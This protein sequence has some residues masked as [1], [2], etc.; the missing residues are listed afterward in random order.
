[1]FWRFMLGASLLANLVLAALWYRAST[2][3]DAPAP[4]PPALTNTAG[5]TNVRTAV[6]VRRQF[7]SW[8]ELESPDYAVY[9]GN[10]RA[11]GCPEET[12]R[13][14]LL[15]DVNQMLRAKYPPDEVAPNPRWWTN[16]RPDESAREEPGRALNFIKERND[17]MTQLFGPNWTPGP[18]LNSRMSTAPTNQIRATLEADDH[19]RNLTPGQKQ[20]VIEVLGAAQLETSGKEA[21]ADPVRWEVL[22]DA[23]SPD[24]LELVKL[25]FSRWAEDLREQ[26][27]HLP[28]FDTQPEE[29]RNI[30][31]NTAGLQ[32]RLAGLAGRDDPA[33]N[34]ERAALNAELETAIRNALTPERY[35]TYVRLHDPAYLDTLYAIGNREATPDTLALIYAINRERNAEQARIEND[36]TLTSAQREI[37]LK[38]LELDQLKAITLAQGEALPPEPDA[39]SPPRP[40]PMKTHNVRP[41][42]GLH[43]IASVYGV[44]PEVLRAANPQL[45]FNHLPAGAKVNVPLRYLYPLPP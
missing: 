28:G 31:R 10:L 6:V 27:D 17:I 9:L 33:A 4:T 37:E 16:V 26:L 8:Q 39:P 41:G 3:A 21:Q 12:I 32:A 29:F 24:Q 43:Q 5:S 15:A 11:I 40:E 35:A 13:D 34:E 18:A 25:H 36:P 45:D 19:L 30:Y 20:L 7:F 42:E 23:L 38:Q 22:R 1:M 14:I 2:P 44:A